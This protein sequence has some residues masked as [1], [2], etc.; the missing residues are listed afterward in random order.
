MWM[1]ELNTKVNEKFAG[2]Q[3]NTLLANHMRAHGLIG[4]QVSSN[5]FVV[6][7]THPQPP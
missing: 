7:P 5:R 4:P 3:A 6:G 2:M 1:Q